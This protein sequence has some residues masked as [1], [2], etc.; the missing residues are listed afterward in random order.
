MIVTAPQ[1]RG[2]SLPTDLSA[3][4]QTHHAFAP[5]AIR[6]DRGARICAGETGETLEIRRRAPYLR[7]VPATGLWA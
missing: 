7:R 3:Q 1:D 2:W 4:N 6:P 5:P